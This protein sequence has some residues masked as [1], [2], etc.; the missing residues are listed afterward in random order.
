MW[1]VV[2]VALLTSSTRSVGPTVRVPLMSG[3]QQGPML[4]FK[5]QWSLCCLDSAGDEIRTAVWQHSDLGQSG[6]RLVVRGESSP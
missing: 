3:R 4:A 1:F 2:V 6:A 5:M